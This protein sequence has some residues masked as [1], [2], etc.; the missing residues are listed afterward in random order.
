MNKL[1]L[2]FLLFILAV[3]CHR[4]SDKI[5]PHVSYRVEENYL[6]SLSTSFPSLSYEE[7]RQDWAR[8]FI[9]A[10][11]FAKE[12]DFYRAIST[13]KRAKILMS[14]AK[15]DRIMQAD[16]SIVLCYY[17]SEKYEDAVDSFEK[18]EL[19]HVEKTFPAYKDLLLIL[20]DSYNKIGEEKKSKQILN[21]IDQKYPDMKKKLSLSTA[22]QKGHINEALSLSQD[23]EH[24]EEIQK[25]IYSYSKEKKSVA[26][27]QLLNTLLPGAGYLYLG[28][29]K[30]A[31]TSLLLNSLFIAAS[32]QF[33][34]KGYTAA[35]I[36]CVTFE[37]G[38]YFSGIYGAGEE[39]KFYNEQLYEEKAGPLMQQKKLFPIFMVEY[40]F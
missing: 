14:P 29:K 4:V 6:T 12:L 24:K 17:L 28:Q 10:E 20:Y 36:I 7:K 35:G 33:F 30:S 19:A 18:S 38:W 2:I 40:T 9:I 32:Y 22:L 25:M 1:N 27:A 15:M 21:A 13:Y 34:H 31:F 5:D 8:E 26:G 11:S 39:A 37:A 3:S 23:M 16:Y